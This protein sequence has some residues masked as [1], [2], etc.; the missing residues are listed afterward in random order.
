MIQNS[1]STEYRYYLSQ[2]NAQNLSS[3]TS[4]T[5]SHP[6]LPIPTPPPS[7]EKSENL[8][9]TEKKESD[10]RS[11]NSLSLM[12]KY[13]E[14]MSASHGSSQGGPEEGPQKRKKKK[15]KKKLKSSAPQS[16][17][18]QPLEQSI[19]DQSSSSSSILDDNPDTSVQ[20]TSSMTKKGEGRGHHLGDHLLNENLF[21]SLSNPTPAKLDQSNIGHQMLMKMG[22]KEGMGLGSSGQGEVEP[23]SS[24]PVK[25]NTLGVGAIPTE[26][27]PS[28]SDIYDL[29][30]RR[31]MLAYRHRPNPLN[32]PRK[33][34][35]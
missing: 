1:E 31:M 13:Y 18:D 27:V 7:E 29:Y 5:N 11:S 28:E 20:H 8:N 33:P 10:D 26:S 14:A 30:K 23:V 32:N 4:K 6:P 22:W 24:G 9:E 3:L 35:Y 12:E 2:L 19:E 17:S 21:P 34:Y 15:K 16:T 25:Q